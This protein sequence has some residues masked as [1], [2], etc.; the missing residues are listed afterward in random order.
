M[1]IKDDMQE[2]VNI[3]KEFDVH[4]KYLYFADDAGNTYRINTNE[5]IFHIL[6]GFREDGAR[7]Y[8]DFFVEYQNDKPGIIDQFLAVAVELLQNEKIN[9]SVEQIYLLHVSRIVTLNIQSFYE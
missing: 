3:C 1:S 6:L 5:V 7:S 2:I 8:Y 4:S 9:D